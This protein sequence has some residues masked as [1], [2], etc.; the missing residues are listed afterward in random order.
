ML[1]F[2]TNVLV[3]IVVADDPSQTEAAGAVLHEAALQGGAWI[4]QV[5]IVETVWALSSRYRFDSRQG[6]RVFA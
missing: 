2:D 3:R 5:V 6:V 1:G 4:S